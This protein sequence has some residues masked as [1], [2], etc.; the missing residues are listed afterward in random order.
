MELLSIVVKL[1]SMNAVFGTV[2][3]EKDPARNLMYRKPVYTTL[4]L[5]KS[6]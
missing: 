1:F 6:T 3:S 2:L 5:L 4:D